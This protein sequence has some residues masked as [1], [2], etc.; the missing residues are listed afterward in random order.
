[1]G[2]SGRDPCT[3]LLQQTPE[4]ETFREFRPQDDRIAGKAGSSENIILIRIA[5]Q[6]GHEASR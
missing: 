1:M 3:N 6:L 2:L 5:V 4:I